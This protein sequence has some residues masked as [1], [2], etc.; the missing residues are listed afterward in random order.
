MDLGLKNKVV[1]VTGASKGIG[2]AVADAFAAEGAKVV[3]AAR[4]AEEVKGIAA[5]IGKQFRTETLGVAAD[6][7]KPQESRGW[8]TRR[9]SVGT[10]HVLVNNA[11]GVGAFA[12]FDQ[13]T[14]DGLAG[15]PE[16][17]RALSRARGA[18]GFAAH[19]KTEVGPHH[20]H[21]QRVGHAA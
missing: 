2:R 11:G 17:Q 1:L 19:A 13:L 20:Q 3:I 7:M 5:D 16:L 12:P 10:V 6:V 9:S 15:N 21:V 8:S 18:S 14:D 4:K